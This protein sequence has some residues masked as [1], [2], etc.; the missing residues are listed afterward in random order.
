MAKIYY[1]GFTTKNYLTS[2]RFDIYNIECVQ[3]D[4][5]NEIFT[6]KGSRLYMP[7][8]G[9]RIPLLIFEINDHYSKNVITEDLLTV[10]SHEPRVTLVNLT[11][12]PLVD[13]N[14]LVASM[15]LT[16]L[17]FNSTTDLNI[18]IKSQ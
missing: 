5:L 6:I 8:Y 4:I 13:S 1:R 12:T 18:E 16:Y 7:D 14:A 3:H 11:V 17:Q 2:H 10:V 15:K 9:T